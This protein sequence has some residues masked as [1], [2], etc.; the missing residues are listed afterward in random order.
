[1]ET[2]AGADFTVPE[3]RSRGTLAAPIYVE[4]ADPGAS[5]IAGAAMA[6]VVVLIFGGFI[7]A[8]SMMG[9]RPEILDKLQTDGV[10]IGGVTVLGTIIF[11]AVGFVLGKMAK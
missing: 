4:A 9:H 11:A 10:M 8:A 3:A 6:V 2:Q 7:L 1:M 5:A